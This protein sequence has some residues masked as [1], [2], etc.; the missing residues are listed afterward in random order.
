M[1]LSSDASTLIKY[2][3]IRT[4]EDNTAIISLGYQGY[5]RIFHIP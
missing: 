3:Q 2:S 4:C 5:L 1:Q